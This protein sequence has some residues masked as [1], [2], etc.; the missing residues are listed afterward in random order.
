MELANKLKLCR[1]Q[2][3]LSQASVAD[4]LNISRQSISKWENGRSYPD[5]DNLILLSDLYQ[6]SIDELLREN[7]RLTQQIQKNKD[8]IKDKQKKV[9]YIQKQIDAEK[10]ES[11]LLLILAGIA[12]LTFPVGLILVIFA[13]WRNSRKNSLYKLVY[14]VCVGALF[15]NFYDGYVHLSNY[16]DWGTGTVEKIE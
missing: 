1:E 4:K 16:L 7:D 13:L 5:I 8:V 6:V 3:G 11:F 14:V 10:D 9:D 12:S 2:S 15:L